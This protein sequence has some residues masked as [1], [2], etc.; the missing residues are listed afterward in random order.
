MRKK[1]LISACLLGI[2]CRWNK[3]QKL[4]KKALELFLKGDAIVV[5]PEVLAGLPTP[6]PACEIR[7]GDGDDVL[8]GKAKI[9][10]NKGK[11]YTKL[12]L[13]GAKKAL[14]LAQKNQITEA[15]LKSG[16]PSC[17]ADLIYSGD[18]TG[19]KKSGR[20]VFAAMLKKNKIKRKELD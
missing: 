11:N 2:P 3:K 9:V 10:D 16:S 14:T 7:G 17:G 15:I 1:Y 20:G 4:N 8:K 12:F 6:R 18:F 13:K 5:C 19:Q